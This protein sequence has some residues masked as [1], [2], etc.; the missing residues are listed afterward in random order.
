MELT[1]E[2]AQRIC[3]LRALEWGYFPLFSTQ[4][5]VPISFLF[6]Q[7]WIVPITLVVATYFWHPVKYNIANLKIAMLVCN[8]NTAL[9]RWPVTIGFSIYF[10]AKKAYVPGIVLLIWPIIVLVMMKF[11]PP[12]KNGVIQ[13]VFLKQMLG[14]EGEKS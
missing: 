12:S 7:W 6:I 13:G 3:L 5:F 4:V 8:L 1:Q 10:I 2:E 9:I 11:C 14:I